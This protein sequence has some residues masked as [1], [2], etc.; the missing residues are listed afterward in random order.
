MDKENISKNTP[1]ESKTGTVVVPNIQ[2]RENQNNPST[3]MSKVDKIRIWAG[4]CF[5]LFVVI[6]VF[7]SIV[8][9]N[10]IAKKEPCNMFSSY[11]NIKLC[12]F[13][14]L[15]IWGLITSFF[16]GIPLVITGISFIFYSIF[17]WKKVKNPSFATF[18]SVILV[19][20]LLILLVAGTLFTIN[21]SL[22]QAVRQA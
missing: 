3:K 11:S 17:H 15:Y 14:G 16:I 7:I 8:V 22:L 2:V 5:I 13:G 18:I 21:M 10:I 19:I 1:N 6:F 12:S 9:P 4:I 20:L